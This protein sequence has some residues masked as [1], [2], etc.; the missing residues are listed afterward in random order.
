[1]AGRN[2]ENLAETT[3]DDLQATI[4]GIPAGNTIRTQILVCYLLMSAITAALGFY[5]M[6]GIKH[7]GNLVAKTFDESLMSINYARAASADFS[8]MRAV[9]S[10]RLCD[11][12]V[13]RSM[14]RPCGRRQ[15]PPH[16]LKARVTADY[17]S[18]Q[19]RM[20]PSWRRHGVI[21]PLSTRLLVT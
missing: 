13:R 5:A 18:E 19:I 6:Q 17:R 15:E 16:R 20:S 21:T 10:R 12:E 4:I 3:V 14:I 9:A 8:K 11:R 1:M 7:A 2:P